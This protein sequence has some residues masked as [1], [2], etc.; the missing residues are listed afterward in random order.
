MMYIDDAHLGHHQRG[1]ELAKDRGEDESHRFVNI[2]GNAKM[3][4]GRDEGGVGRTRVP[5]D[6]RCFRRPLP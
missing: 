1:V 3:L 5:A 2:L 4:E 6:G